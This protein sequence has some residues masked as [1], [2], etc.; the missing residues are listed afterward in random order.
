MTR[1]RPGPS[2][3]PLPVRC[4][5]W[6]SRACASLELAVV[7]IAA[8]VIV[9]AWA[10]LVESWDGAAAAQF[11]FYRAWW[12]VLL[13]A[14]LGLNVLAAVL[15]RFPWRRRQTGFLLTHLGILVLLAGSLVSH[16]KGI[17]SQL[18]ILEGEAAGRAYQA[19]QHFALEIT[20]TDASEVRPGKQAEAIQ[21]P[22]CPGPFNWEDYRQM[23]WFPWRLAQR[24]R[25]CIY[26]RD[27]ITLEVLDYCSDSQRVPLPQITLQVEPDSRSSGSGSPPTVPVE[28]TLAVVAGSGPHAASR[29]LGVGEQQATPQGDRIVFWMTG[30]RAET[31]AFLQSRPEGPL[32]D[33]G[34]VVLYCGGKTFRFN[35]DPW[36]HEP[37]RPLGD[38]GLEVE[39]VRVNT[40]M[41][42]VRIDVHR[43]GDPPQPMT[44]L[45][46]LPHMNRQDDLH[47]V[48]GTYWLDRKAA[49]AAANRSQ[50]TEELIRQARQRRIDVVQGHDRRLYYRTWQAPQVNALAPW[51]A[52]GLEPAPLVGSRVVAFEQS[53]RPIRLTLEEFSPRDSPGWEIRPLP[54]EKEDRKRR[55]SQSRARLRLSVDGASEEFWLAAS[56]GQA[57]PDQRHLVASKGR[58][59]SISLVPD[60]VDLGFQVFLRRFNRKLDPGT[61]AVSH[62]SSLVDFCDPDDTDKRLRENVSISLN[63]PVSFTDPHSGRS[64]RLYQSSYVGPWKPGDPQFDQVVGGAEVRDRLFQSVLAVNSDPGRGL[65]YLGCLMICVG[66]LMVFYLRKLP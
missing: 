64:Y 52:D 18:M 17:D 24:S 27:G 50:V 60:Y 20:P 59:V 53:E 28:M 4:V 65:K 54:F 57:L 26:N 46:T 43:P 61:S 36:Q 6:L 49:P 47:G 11:G 14:L 41:L 5:L 15:I 44:L 58:Q 19:T 42:G 29:P 51:P 34:Q 40:M 38:S 2:E 31:E 35:V 62:Y 23:G 32:G 25:A 7:L 3:R 22:F 33:L 1:S 48:Y 45:A 9:L 39:L 66:I 13:I 10:T 16:L 63:A 30:S 21:V 8:C 55:T 37:R 56:I 12:F